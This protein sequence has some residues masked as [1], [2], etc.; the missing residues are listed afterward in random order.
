ML[1]T[2]HDLSL[3]RA[4]QTSEANVSSGTSTYR[5]STQRISGAKCRPLFHLL[6][7]ENPPPCVQ[8]ESKAK[9]RIQ[10]K[11]PTVEV[12]SS[13]TPLMLQRW[14][15]TKR[16]RVKFFEG[17]LPPSSCLLLK[18]HTVGCRNP[19]PGESALQGMN[20]FLSIVMLVKPA[21][22]CENY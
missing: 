8:L 7:C 16:E 18:S 12:F 5:F 6:P 14:R 10:F 13:L 19:S 17:H 20:A 2:S 22:R 11:F 1:A 3:Y 9:S 21:R 4:G 15:N